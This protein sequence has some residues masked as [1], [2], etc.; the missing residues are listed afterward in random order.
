[1]IQDLAQEPAASA[2]E[3]PAHLTGNGSLTSPDLERSEQISGGAQG[4][5]AC[6]QDAAWVNDAL[7]AMDKLPI[8]SPESC[9]VVSPSLIYDAIIGESVYTGS[10]ASSSF[11][12]TSALEATVISA[13]AGNEIPAIE[14]TSRSSKSPAL[15]DDATDAG[16]ECSSAIFSRLEQ[17][18]VFTSHQCLLETLLA[19]RDNVVQ[20]EA[21]SQCKHCLSSSRS[22]LLLVMFAEKLAD[23]LRDLLTSKKRLSTKNSTATIRFA[24]YVTRSD[25]E[26]STVY[27][28]LLRLHTHRFRAMVSGLLDQALRSGWTGQVKALRGLVANIDEVNRDITQQMSI[29]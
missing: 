14:D 10:A 3:S 23:Q 1:M 9:E 28:A 16:C 15:E 21:L 22:V 12:S 8:K 7:S 26:C 27:L 19:V 25:Q 2:A 17:M 24:E 13:V 29:Y 18:L 4:L 6:L 11:P 5:L 20:F